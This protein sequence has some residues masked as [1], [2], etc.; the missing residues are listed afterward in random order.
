MKTAACNLFLRI[1]FQSAYFLAA[2]VP[3]F[4]RPG[5]SHNSSNCSARRDLLSLQSATSFLKVENYNTIVNSA[6]LSTECIILHGLLIRSNKCHH[7]VLTFIAY[8]SLPKGN[9]FWALSEIESTA[10]VFRTHLSPF[11]LLAF[12]LYFSV[13]SLVDCNKSCTM[14]ASLP[15]LCSPGFLY[16]SLISLDTLDETWTF[17]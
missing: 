17:F 1:T 9:F 12:V 6:A 7:P 11:Q 2:P 8:L 10:L 13:S 15:Y 3:Y 14:S 5:T 4:Q 16:N